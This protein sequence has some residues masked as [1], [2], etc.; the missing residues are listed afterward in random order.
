MNI[1][2]RPMEGKP[3]LFVKY[4][5]L[6]IKNRRED[7]NDEIKDDSLKQ[8]EQTIYW[9][10][11]YE[12]AL[13]GL[14]FSDINMVFYRRFKEFL[15]SH[16][17]REASF[18]KHIKHI[19]TFM[20]W[21]KKKGL[22]KNEHFE[23]FRVIKKQADDEALTSEEFT[24]L[25][26][27]M[28]SMKEVIRLIEEHDRIRLVGQSAAKRFKSFLIHRDV[29]C[30]L[31]SSGMYIN[32]LLNLSYDNIVDNS[33]VKYNRFK[34]S[35]EVESECIID[36]EEDPVLKFRELCE[37]YDYNFTVKMRS[38]YTDVKV[39][40]K[41][42]G[43]DKSITTKSG[44]K[45]WASI[46]YYERNAPMHLIMKGLGH[47]KEEST[48]HYLRVQEADIADQYKEIKKA[49]KMKDMIKAKGHGHKIYR[50]L[51]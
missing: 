2:N 24:T 32:D 40:M 44:R 50:K 30:A 14:S 51:G 9:I 36:F 17:I 25:Y 27:Q 22:H 49:F 37:R 48:R 28:F 11:R 45:T 33:Y 7:P 16:Q 35:G 3:S 34:K 21:A 38:I 18:G 12:K 19:K 31:C 47:T 42:L 13:K 8:F 43:I 1:N 23:D 15:N 5:N 26:N 4:F 20:S 6:Y 46:W 41:Y 39:M 29:F 10:R